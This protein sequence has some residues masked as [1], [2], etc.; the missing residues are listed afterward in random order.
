MLAAKRGITDTVR[1]LL[2]HGADVNTEDKSGMLYTI[3]KNHCHNVYSSIH[4][5]TFISVNIISIRTIK[6]ILNPI[7]LY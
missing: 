1:I 5:Y 6:Y 4:L 7:Y 2:E 3:I